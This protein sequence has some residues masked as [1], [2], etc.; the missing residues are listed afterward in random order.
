MIKTALIG[1]GY[2]ASTFHAPLIK[3]HP[4][5]VL[6]AVQSSREEAVKA[7]LPNVRVSADTDALLSDDDI[8][9][10]II[11]A[12][13]HLHFG[14]AKACLEAGKHVVLEKPFVVSAQE[15]EALIALAEKQQR[16]LTVFHNRR[17]D[18]D[19]LTL[20]KVIGEETLGPIH[21]MA[22]HFDRF[23][24]VVRDRWRERDVDGG[25]IWYDLGPHLLDQAFVLFGEPA[26]MSG[27]ITSLR[28]DSPAADFFHVILH[29]SDKQVVVQSSPYCATPTLRFDLQGEKGSYRKFGLDTQESALKQGTVPNTADWITAL[30]EPAGILCLGEGNEHVLPT[31]HGQ[32]MLFFD[33]LSKA[34][35][36]GGEP[37]VKPEQ[38]L[39]VIRWIEKMEQRLWI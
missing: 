6:T 1:F 20:Q 35:T 28:P 36:H 24:P 4:D 31:Q 11:T 33:L 17:W 5:Y 25:G 38:A 22:S 3:N 7:A 21:F 18:G 19:F 12:P 37:P 26:D 23:R 15:G 29:Y 10:V 30:E 32:Y 13:N 39:Q 2:S 27:T 34:I 9:L 16:V 8:D 14:L